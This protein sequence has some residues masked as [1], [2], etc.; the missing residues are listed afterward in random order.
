MN[1]RLLLWFWMLGAVLLFNISAK[2][3]IKPVAIDTTALFPQL[4]AA[5]VDGRQ[6][7]MKSFFFDLIWLDDT[8]FYYQPQGTYYL[9]KV[10]VGQQME[11]QQLSKAKYHGNSYHR[12]HFLW[13][14]TVY[15]FCGSGMFGFSNTL[16]YFDFD[17]REW[18]PHPIEGFPVRAKRPVSLWNHRDTLFAVMGVWP[19]SN[20]YF[21]LKIS[22]ESLRCIEAKEIEHND[23]Y[24]LRLEHNRILSRSNR[25]YIFDRFNDK[26]EQG[27]YLYNRISCERSI[28]DFL[29][30]MDFFGGAYSIALDDTFIYKYTPSDGWQKSDIAQTILQKRGMRSVL[31]NQPAVTEENDTESWIAGSILLMFVFIAL[32]FSRFSKEGEEEQQKAEIL[33]KLK[34]KRKSNLTREELDEILNLTH[35]TTDSA[36]VMRSRWIKTLNASEEIT[37]VRVRNS[38]D[39]RM[40]LYSVN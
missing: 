16:L 14:S 40:F 34:L 37:I 12:Y 30:N 35:L 15:I 4:R 32:Y 18:I 24:P 31:E 39:K 38:D 36:K 28:I 1:S 20:H 11:V 21:Y 3:T 22:M 8:T 13:D 2:A 27:L 10:V 5:I 19:T 33:A 7:S 25:Y 26:G 29:K 9:Y 23:I 17:R 6:L